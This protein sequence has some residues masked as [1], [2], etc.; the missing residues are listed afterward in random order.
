ME[1]V[2]MMR[3][4]VNFVAFQVGWFGCVMTAARG[5]YWLGPAIV[6]GV[7][8]LHLAMSPNRAREARLLALVGVCGGLAYTAMAVLGVVAFPADVGTFMIAIW[9]MAFWANF[10]TV[11]TG[12]MN[13]LHGRV[14]LAVVLGAV[15]GPPA[16]YSAKLMGAIDLPLNTWK[17]V[18]PLAIYWAIAFPLAIRVAAAST[19]PVVAK[20]AT[21]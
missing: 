16:Y 5:Q 1:R 19:P 12:P 20:G 18:A 10:A 14:L 9:F 6:L 3:L 8:A 11:L 7:I 17:T 4:I 15:F 13:W 2:P 21:S